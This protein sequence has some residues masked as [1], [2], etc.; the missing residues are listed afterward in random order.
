ME[1]FRSPRSRAFPGGLRNLVLVLYAAV[2]LLAPLSHHD[3]ACHIKSTTHCTTCVVGSSGECASI[4]DA[5]PRAGFA[6]SGAA[7]APATAGFESVPPANCAGR[8]PPIAG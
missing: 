4:H 3:L 1:R 2:T 8:A 5:L 6:D 7:G